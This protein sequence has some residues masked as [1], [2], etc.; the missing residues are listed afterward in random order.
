MSYSLNS[1]K[2]VLYIYISICISVF[3]LYGDSG[4][5]SLNWGCIGDYNRGY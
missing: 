3:R 4:L 5:N 1:L 2:G